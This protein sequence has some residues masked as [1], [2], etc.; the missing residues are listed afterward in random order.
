MIKGLTCARTHPRT[1]P[2]PLPYTTQLCCSLFQRWTR[3]D[4]SRFKKLL[5][6]LG[7]GGMPCVWPGAEGLTYCPGLDP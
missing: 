5:K 6:G 2:A 1:P 4:S 7:K 3:T